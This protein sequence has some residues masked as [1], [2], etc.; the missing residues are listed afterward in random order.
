MFT[1]ALGS[2]Q[3]LLAPVATEQQVL[4]HGFTPQVIVFVTASMEGMVRQVWVLLRSSMFQHLQ[5]DVTDFVNGQ[6]AS[7][8]KTLPGE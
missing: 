7:D 4:T 1:V 3:G 2:L 5:I 8:P 6:Y